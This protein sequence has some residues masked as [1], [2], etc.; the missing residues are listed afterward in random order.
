MEV[1]LLAHSF[2]YRH[3]HM[4]T[5]TPHTN[6]HTPTGVSMH[7]CTHTHTLCCSLPFMVG[8]ILVR[9]NEPSKTSHHPP[10]QDSRALAL[11]AAQAACQQMVPVQKECLWKTQ[12]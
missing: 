1:L 4:H 11:Q 12:G 5:P 7:A 3:T 9:N 10:R 6:M 8:E 2:P